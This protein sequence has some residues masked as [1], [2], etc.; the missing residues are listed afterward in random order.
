[1][2]HVVIDP[3]LVSG[4][5]HLQQNRLTISLPI[6]KP[7]SSNKSP[8]FFQ[9]FSPGSEIHIVCLGGGF[10]I[11]EPQTSLK[12]EAAMGLIDYLADKC[13]CYDLVDVVHS[14]K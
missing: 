4:I 6:N 11:T 14:L 3:C 1:M 7:Q 5:L 12:D 8:Y 13:R 9:A 10:I 2:N